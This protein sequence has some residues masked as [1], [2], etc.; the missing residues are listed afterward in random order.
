MAQLSKINHYKLNQASIDVKHI[1]INPNLDRKT[2]KQ[3]MK[4]KFPTEQKKHEIFE[5]KDLDFLE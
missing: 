2:P 5:G 1:S 4:I 3:N